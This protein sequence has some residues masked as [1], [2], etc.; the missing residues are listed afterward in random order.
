MAYLNKFDKKANRLNETLVLIRPHLQ[1]HYHCYIAIYV[2][3]DRTASRRITLAASAS[4]L[5]PINSY[6]LLG[7]TRCDMQTAAT[8][9]HR[10]TYW[11]TRR[12][13]T[14]CLTVASRSVPYMACIAHVVTDVSCSM[15]GKHM[16]CPC[17]YSLC[18]A[19][20][21][22]VRLRCKI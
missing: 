16:R 7:V 3:P 14:N 9:N 4:N 12:T 22:R 19:E 1:Q 17:V 10:K 5:A 11:S 21:I 18:K 20:V 8:F 13:P 2:A 15:R 6:H